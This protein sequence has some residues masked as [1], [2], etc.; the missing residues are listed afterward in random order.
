M[1]CKR[2]IPNENTP[3]FGSAQF[4]VGD[5][6]R[7]EKKCTK[8]YNTKEQLFFCSLFIVLLRSRYCCRRGL[9]KFSVVSLTA[10]SLSANIIMVWISK[11]TDIVKDHQFIN[12]GWLLRV[13]KALYSESLKTWHNI[14]HAFSEESSLLLLLLL[15]KCRHFSNVLRNFEV[16]GI[17]V[18]MSTGTTRCNVT[19]T[20]RV[21]VIPAFAVA[22]MLLYT[23]DT[24]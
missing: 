13:Q 3:S 18:I 8:N 9:F 1:W 5:V 23:M 17:V 6:Q 12:N 15:T 11:L 19:R 4:H 21:G 20:W 2:S 16:C 24:R 10:R 7:T 22:C 14:L